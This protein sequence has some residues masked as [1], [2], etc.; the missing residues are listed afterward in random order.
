MSNINYTNI[1]E[2][3]PVAGQDNDSQGFR[4]NFE[5]IKTALQVTKA[6][7]TELQ[8]NSVLTASLDANEIVDNDLQNSTINNGKYSN[9]NPL[10][11]SETVAV[12]TFDLVVSQFPVRT[13]LLTGN[14]TIN[15]DDW[16]STVGDASCGKVIIHL[17]SST[18]SFQVNFQQSAGTIKYSDNF[19]TPFTV[20]AF[21]AGTVDIVEAWSYNNGA[22]VYMRYLGKYVSTRSN[23]RTITGSLSVNGSSTFGDSITDNISFAGVPRFPQMTTAQRTSLT[24]VAGMVIFNTTTV[25]LELCTVSGGPGSATWIELN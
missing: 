12:D 8:T 22:T 18:N 10:F 9:F 2:L 3:Y 15:F 14:V 21:S 5:T 13:L 1:D 17:S 20:D 7:I 19:P 24:G 23:N 25:K 4:D 6:E 16:H 11:Q